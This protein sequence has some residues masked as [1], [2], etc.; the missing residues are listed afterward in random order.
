MRK[1]LLQTRQPLVFL[2]ASQKSKIPF[3]E[4]FCKASQLKLKFNFKNVSRS[5]MKSLVPFC[6]KFE[7]KKC[8][9]KEENKKSG[10]LLELHHCTWD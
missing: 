8:K 7:K 6:I 5:N 3:K 9:K 2:T 10:L 1:P 4:V